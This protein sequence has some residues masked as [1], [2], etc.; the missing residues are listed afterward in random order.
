MDADPDSSTRTSVSVADLGQTTAPMSRLEAVP[1][2]PAAPARHP[3]PAAIADQLEETDRAASAYLDRIEV[4]NPYRVTPNSASDIDAI[5]ARHTEQVLFGQMTPE[6]AAQS[7]ID[8]LQKRNPHSVS[9]MSGLTCPARP[10]TSG[11][12]RPSRSRAA[13]GW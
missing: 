7:F 9:E 6:R 2:R 11:W 12:R 13:P 1:G 8:E 4:G 5:L 10:A 3:L